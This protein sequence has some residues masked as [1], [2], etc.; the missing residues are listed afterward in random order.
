MANG[1]NGQSFSVDWRSMGLV[2]FLVGH[3]VTAV[4]FG[5]KVTEQVDRLRGDVQRL[6]V[7]IDRLATRVAENQ[8]LLNR[9]DERLQ[10]SEG[11]IDRAEA[12]ARRRHP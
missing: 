12:E 5:G 7:S 10:A 9:H 8:V 6:A 1:I 4:F 3:L 11:R 2:L